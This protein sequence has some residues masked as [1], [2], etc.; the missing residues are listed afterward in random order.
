MRLISALN[1]LGLWNDLVLK[2][3]VLLNFPVLNQF[4]EL[5][6]KCTEHYGKDSAHGLPELV[7]ISKLFQGNRSLAMQA[8]DAGQV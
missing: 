1:G 7:Y 6:T 5:H 4:K 2:V 8:V 3:C